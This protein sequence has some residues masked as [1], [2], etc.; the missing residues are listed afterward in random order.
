MMLQKHN[1]TERWNRHSHETTI[2]YSWLELGQGLCLQKRWL[3]PLTAC[4]SNGSGYGILYQHCKW[5][6]M[7]LVL[8][9]GAQIVLFEDINKNW[10]V[11][12][13]V[14]TR[15]GKAGDVIDSIAMADQGLTCSI[16]I[17]I[18]SP[19]D[20]A[21]HIL[22]NLVIMIPI[23]SPLAPTGHIGQSGSQFCPSNHSGI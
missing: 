9:V 17:P 12:W 2:S 7:G 21:G 8:T 20:P 4:L 22:V 14:A 16:M 13:P 1:E 10:I 6:D 15:N 11:R 23:M 5:F 3:V 18:R 19:L